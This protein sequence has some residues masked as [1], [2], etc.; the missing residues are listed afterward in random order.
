MKKHFLKA[1]NA[2]TFLLVACCL[3]ACNKE[4]EV[5]NPN[6]IDVSDKLQIVLRSEDYQAKKKSHA[7]P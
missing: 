4:K 6:V 7:L 2:V 3:A 5:E 1:F